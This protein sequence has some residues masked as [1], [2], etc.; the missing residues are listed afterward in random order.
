MLAV[1]VL[2]STN[3][4][5]ANPTSLGYGSA[6]WTLPSSGLESRPARCAIS[7]ATRQTAMMTAKTGNQVLMTLAKMFAGLFCD[8]ALI[9]G[10]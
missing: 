2:Q 9:L 10:E 8:M 5:L 7:A 4:S 1:S 3:I 6:G